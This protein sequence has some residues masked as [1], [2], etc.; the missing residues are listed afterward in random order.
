[1]S[2]F[3]LFGDAKASAREGDVQRKHKAL[4]AAQER[5]RSDPSPAN[6]MAVASALFDLGRFADAEKEL[7]SLKV[8][9]APDACCV[10]GR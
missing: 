9:G 2:K 6:R 7:S 8:D 5:Q 4:N 1:M 10:A 3:T